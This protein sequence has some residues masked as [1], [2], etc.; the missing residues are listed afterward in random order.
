MLFVRREGNLAAYYARPG[1]RIVD[2]SVS[3]ENPRPG[4]HYLDNS[5][6]NP[7]LQRERLQGNFIRIGRDNALFCLIG[8]HT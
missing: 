1:V 8:K 6:A 7:S 4:D 3:A 5:R 2:T